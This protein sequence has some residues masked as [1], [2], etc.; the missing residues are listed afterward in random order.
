MK[1]AGEG[2]QVKGD[3]MRLV[4]HGRSIH[5]VRPSGDAAGNRQFSRMADHLERGIGEDRIAEFRV[6]ERV[7]RLAKSGAGARVG[8]VYVEHGVVARLLQ[9][10]LDVQIKCRV[11]LASQQQE[12]DRVGFDFAEEVP[13]ENDVSAALGHRVRL[14]VAKESHKPAQLDIQFDCTSGQR[15]TA[16]FMRR[17]YPP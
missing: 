8:V 17:T 7:R 9:R 13:Q 14:T 12:P 10:P 16:A 5:R 3:P 15:D 11:V 4:R 2:V 6:R 1:I